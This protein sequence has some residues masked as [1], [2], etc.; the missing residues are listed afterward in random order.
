[1]QKKSNK[2]FRINSNPCP[3]RDL[4]CRTLTTKLICY[5]LSYPSSDGEILMFEKIKIKTHYNLQFKVFHC[6]ST[7]HLDRLHGSFYLAGLVP[8][9]K[10]EE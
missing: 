4:N 2:F 3:C 8:L 1:M 6:L 5:Q 9:K 10:I 7:H